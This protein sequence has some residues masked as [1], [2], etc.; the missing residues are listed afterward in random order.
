MWKPFSLTKNRA[1]REIF[2]RTSDKQTIDALMF[3]WSEI[4]HTSISDIFSAAQIHPN[5]WIKI[6]VLKLAYT[7]NIY[8]YIYIYIYI[9]I[10]IHQLQEVISSQKKNLQEVISSQKKKFT[11]GY[12]SKLPWAF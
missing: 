6:V 2:A 4:F 9:L 12:T 3:H 8:I 10:H 7:Q 11:R 5:V 1:K